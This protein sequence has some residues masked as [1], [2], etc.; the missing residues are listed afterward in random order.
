[1]TFAFDCRVCTRN[2]SVD[3]HALDVFASVQYIRQLKADEA[4]MAHGR[5]EQVATPLPIRKRDGNRKS[6]QQLAGTGS[7]VN[8]GATR[9]RQKRRSSD[10]AT[11]G[12]CPDDPSEIVIV[13]IG[14]S[15]GGC[16]LLLYALF[17]AAI[18]V[19]H[20]LSK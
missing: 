14:H 13:G 15:M 2:Y 6:P 11:I 19:P 5:E 1:M 10:A 12:S 18:G 3:D 20:G 7:T 4:E 17:C 9:R 16:S 8:T